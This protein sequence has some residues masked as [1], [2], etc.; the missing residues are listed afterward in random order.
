MN[1]ENMQET[2]EFQAEV[3]QLLDIVI[4]SLYT[5]KEIFLRELISNAAD[6][7]E[8]C[9]YLKV[10]GEDVQHDDLPLEISITTDNI[11]HTLTVADTGTGMSREELVENLGTIAHSGS[12]DFIKRLAEGGT[13]DLSLIGQ[14][15]VG[16]Y[17]AFMVAEKVTLYTRS[18]KP[19][20]EGCIWTSEGTGRYT[21]SGAKD[22]KRGTKIVLQLKKDANEFAQA[23]NIKSIIKQYSGYVPYPIKLNGEKVNTVQALWTKNKNEVSE[24]E[25]NEF[26]KY[27]SN[28]YEEPLFRLHFTADA[29]LS[30]NALLFV[31]KDNF[32]QYGFSRLEP[33]VSLY[34]R[35]VLIQDQSEAI[36]PEWLRFVKGVVDSEELP[37]NISRETMQDSALVAKL[38]RVITG[39]FL[40][41]LN[42]QAE[43]EPEKY[44]EFWKKFGMFL[45]EGAASDFAYR[46]ELVKLMRFESSKT[47]AGEFISLEQYLERMK[48]GQE[49][50]YYVNGPSRETIEAGPYMEI[51][52]ER[53]LEVI[54]TREAVDDYILSQMGKYQEKQL[55]SAD[56]ANIDLSKDSN[57]NESLNEAEIKA[58]TAWVQEVLGEKVSEVRASQRLVES[59]AV[60]LS[61]EGMTNSIQRMMQAMNEN[62]S[63]MGS[64]ILEIN[65]SHPIIK[66]LNILREEEEDFAKT[67]IEQVFHNALTSAGLVID[68]RDAVTR[69]YQIM[70]RAL[71]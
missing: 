5:D 8:K 50:I 11:A 49:A 23:D 20:A 4:N 39:R 25:Y 44:Q 56:E 37:L 33:G 41:F 42:E 69:I 16:F 46:D 30:I 66:R 17:A 13:G 27:L 2:K 60:V 3:K 15:G 38:R 45:K 43:K 1:N 51:F 29:P 52:H 62:N 58:L 68:P 54:Y 28:G 34:C 63:S 9:R 61:P 19:E 12:K 55:K 36:L 71:G 21:I 31:P 10:T 53:D 32:E 18:Y 26:Y 6:A 59:P 64:H 70:E 57:E 40:K 35:K 22:L 47:E 7:L 65:C 14:F 24:E 48:E 67:A